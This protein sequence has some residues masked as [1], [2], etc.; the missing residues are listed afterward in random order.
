MARRS[1]KVAILAGGKGS[2][3]AEETILKPKPMVEVGGKPLL[4]H[5]MRQYARFGFRDFVIALG[6]KGA[7]IKQYFLNYH[8]LHSDVTVRLSTGQV[9]AQD[10]ELEDWTVRLVDTG[11]ETQTGGRIKRL[12][13]AVG[14]GTFLL[15]Y[16]DGIADVDL[17]ALLA[18]HREQ[19]R[20]ATVT[21]VR[22]PS[23]FGGL[24]IERDVVEEFVEKPQI[25]EGWINGGFFVLEPKALD[26]IDGD[27]T[28]FEREPLERLAKDGQLA[29]YRHQG[30]WQCVDTPRD[31]RLLEERWR[32]NHAGWT[33]KV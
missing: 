28:M 30:F 1:M 25:G 3:L 16:G 19:G 21:A 6:Y 9:S 32:S 7:D 27:E 12:A 10:G 20:L 14:S 18:F 4:W 26:Y 33:A 24:S 11:L 2:R 15:T 13:G 31:L 23:R 8:L 17:L 5:I 22:P 29:A